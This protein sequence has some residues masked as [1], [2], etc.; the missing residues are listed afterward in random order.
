MILQFQ[1]EELCGGYY[2]DAGTAF[3]LVLGQLS[4]CD[5]WFHAGEAVEFC[6]ILL[7]REGRS[8]WV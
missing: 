8:W 3:A 1:S 4:G 5:V 7:R 6:G 2:V